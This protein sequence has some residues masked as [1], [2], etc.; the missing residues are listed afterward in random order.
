M[1]HGLSVAEIALRVWRNR[2]QTGVV[3]DGYQL[4][5]KKVPLPFYLTVA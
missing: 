3:L 1:Y 4:S 5:Y 2:L